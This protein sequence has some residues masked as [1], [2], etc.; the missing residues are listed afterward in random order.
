MW[1]QG[2]WEPPAAFRCDYHEAHHQ[3]AL[4]EAKVRETLAASGLPPRLQVYRWTRYREMVG[5]DGAFIP[6]A[7]RATVTPEAFAAFQ[8]SLGDD[9]LGITPWNRRLAMEL[10]GMCDPGATVRTVLITGPVGTGKST[11]VAATVA[12]LVAAGREVFYISEAELLERVRREARNRNR[13]KGQPA[14]G[15]VASLARV[16]ILALDDLGIVEAPKDWHLDAMDQ[17]FSYRYDH[18][19][20]VLITTNA[21]LQELADVY[22]E[23][24]ASRLVEMTGRVQKSLTGP[25]WRTGMLRTDADPVEPDAP[26]PAPAPCPSCGRSPCRCPCPECGYNPCRCGGVA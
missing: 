1:R 9:V 10:R 26:A 18:R 23:R 20:P 24:L 6:V 17:I 4:L 2:R 15:I 16:P 5:G 13:S 25:D 19:L 7:A 12:G 8:A 14:V 3:A 11:L 22:G 21:D